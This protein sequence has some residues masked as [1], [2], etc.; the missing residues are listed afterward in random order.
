ME[1]ESFP[2]YTRIALSIA[3]RIANGELQEKQRLNGRSVLSSEYN[4][5][6]ETIRK[7]LSLLKEMGIVEMQEGSGSTVLSRAKAIEYLQVMKLRREQ[8]EL[9]DQL[10]ALFRDYRRIGKQIEDLSDELISAYFNPLP[11]EQAIPT[12]EVEIAPQSDKVGMSLYE[13]HFWESTGATVVALKRGQYTSVSAGPYVR[14]QPEDVLVCVGPPDCKSNVERFLNG[15]LKEDLA[16]LTS[17][18]ESRLIVP[19]QELDVLAGI[20]SCSREE[21][22]DITPLSKGMTN[23]SFLF[24]CRGSRYILRIPGEGTEKLIN[25]RQ[26]AAVYQA[27]A[28]RGLCDDPIYIDP[29]S[30]LKVTR[31]LPDVRTCDPYNRWDVADCMKKLRAFHQM[32]LKVEHSFDLFERL[33]YY[34]SLWEGQASIWTDYAQTKADILKLRPFIEAHRGHL[35]LCHVDPVADNFLF[36]RQDGADQL[37]LADWEYAG[38]QDPH[39]DLAMFCIYSL[40][41]RANVDHLID[42]YFEGH[43]PRDIRT[44]IYCYIAVC[45]LLWSNWSE[46]KYH[47]NVDYSEYARRQYLYAKEYYM[48]AKERISIYENN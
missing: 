40:Y 11:S 29:V 26:E 2:Q 43:C 19:D 27:I 18:R 28:G 10:G 13:L 34:E 32:D 16:A 20:F 46:Y 5:S 38:M 30:G 42:V 35:C 36:Y 1:R 31:F 37:Q 39:M 33:E 17:S 47:L 21:I 12:F 9:R 41:D 6:P 7:S 24:T 22:H 25:R 23:H 15:H 8:Q 4:V 3:S 48:I 14:L 45:G 44:K